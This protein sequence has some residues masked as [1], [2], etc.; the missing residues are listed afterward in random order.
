MS[1][2]LDLVAESRDRFVPSTRVEYLVLQ[3]ARQLKAL[4]NLRELLILSE[5]YS[6]GVL[7][8]AFRATRDEGNLDY[9]SFLRHFSAITQQN[10]Q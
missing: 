9:A 4:G 6:E 10:D 3:M 5:H 8:R 1:S 7:V 2:I